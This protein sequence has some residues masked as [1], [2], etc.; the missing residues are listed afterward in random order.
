MGGGAGQTA[1]FFPYEPF[2]ERSEP[3][4]A[5]NTKRMPRVA[6]G[7]FVLM[8]SYYPPSGGQGISLGLVRQYRCAYGA[9]SSG[10]GTPTPPPITPELPK[11][12]AVVRGSRGR[13]F[14][15][16]TAMERCKRT[17]TAGRALARYP[18]RRMAGSN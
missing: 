12:S 10:G 8:F 17:D 15:P 9:P 1:H 18:A 5:I 7:A 11:H 3:L 2:M 6:N 14:S 16:P 13:W 4:N